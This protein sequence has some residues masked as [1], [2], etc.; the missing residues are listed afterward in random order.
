MRPGAAE[1]AF[2]REISYDRVGFAYDG[3]EAV[4]KDVSFT[5]PRGSIVAI[6][7]PSGAG[8]TTLIELLPRFHDPVDRRDSPGWRAADP[9]PAGLGARADGPGQPGHRAAQ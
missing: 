8:K 4:L 3:G 6:V 1:A 2:A 5:V 9:A 7:G